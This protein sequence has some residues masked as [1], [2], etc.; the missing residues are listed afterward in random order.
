MNIKIQQDITCKLKILNHAK[1]IGNIAKTCC[2]FGICRETFY[3][4]K[5]IYDKESEQGLINSKPCPENHK[6]R[7][8]KTIEEK[9]VHL[10]QTYH[11]GPDMIVWHLL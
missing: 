10:R 1:K 4:W 8:P 2:Y 9:I 6:L 3:K 5:M 7:I 11:F